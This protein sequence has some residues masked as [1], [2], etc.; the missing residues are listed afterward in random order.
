MSALQPA[1]LSKE[2]KQKFVKQLLTDLSDAKLYQKWSKLRIEKA[3][4]DLKTLGRDPVGCDKLFEKSS[5]AMLMSHAGIGVDPRRGQRLLFPDTEVAC[6]AFT[7]LA[8]MFLNQESTRTS[9]LDL[10]MVERVCALKNAPACSARS[11]F[12]FAR[13]LFLLTLGR[14]KVV[15]RAIEECH[16]NSFISQLLSHHLDIRRRGDGAVGGPFTSPQIIGELLKVVYNVA[17]EYIAHRSPHFQNPALQSLTLGSATLRRTLPTS[18]TKDAHPEFHLTDAQLNTDDHPSFAS[19]LE[20]AMDTLLHIAMDTSALSIPPPH[21]NAISVL[22]CYSPSAF[23]SVFFPQSDT[24][25]LTRRLLE[26]SDFALNL[27]AMN[28]AGTPSCSTSGGLA[29]N[30]TSF[31]Q[32][33]SPSFLPALWLL[34]S[35]SQAHIPSRL[36]MRNHWFPEDR[37]RSV[38]PESIDSTGGRL[39]FILAQPMPTHLSHSVGNLLFNLWNNDV[40]QL[41]NEVGYGNAAGY[42]AAQ[43]IPFTTTQSSSSEPSLAARTHSYSGSM[44]I[45]PITGQAM[46]SPSNSQRSIQSDPNLL[47]DMQAVFAEMTM[48]EKEQEAEKLMVLFDRL[49][50]TGV[51]E[52]EHPLAKATKEGILEEISSSEESD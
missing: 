39:V 52:F 29:F 15:E 33:V 19:L 47:G 49:Q 14:T 43:G 26:I 24:L 31:N 50:R 11:H 44:R 22:L 28:E 8:N 13:V 48:E 45:N 5:I 18:D 9:A 42:L 27:L 12:L 25:A 7:C 21:C 10:R 1:L 37:D 4:F 2:A 51:V 41:V 20:P 35:I 23:A 3:L 17:S 46:S 36:E 34:I 6:E 40:N 38:S 32:N 30:F 16:I